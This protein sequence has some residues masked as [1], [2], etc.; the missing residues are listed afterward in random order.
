MAI[1]LQFIN[2]VI[3][4]ATLERVFAAE[5][6][7]QGY[8][9]EHEAALGE[10]VWHDA[11]LCRV[12]GTMNW[13]DLDEMVARWEMRGLQG[14]VGARPRQWWK[15]FAVCASRRGATFPCDW[16]EYDAA[17]NCV[18]LVGTPKGEVTGPFPLS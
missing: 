1:R 2:L 12:D 10:L 8:L 17:D 13:P 5:G 11:H 15:D 6:G 9:R 14:L 4:V 7:F 18:H 16:L 3:T